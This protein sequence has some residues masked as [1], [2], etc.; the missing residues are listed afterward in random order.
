MVTDK[1]GD[2][3]SFFSPSGNLSRLQFKQK[4]TGHV[5]IFIPYF[6]IP[7]GWINNHFGPGFYYYGELI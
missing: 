5:T 1:N 3:L 4:K 2:V 6:F 7:Q